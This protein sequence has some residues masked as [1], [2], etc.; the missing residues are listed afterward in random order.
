MAAAVAAASTKEVAMVVATEA[1]AT[2]AVAT[3]A[4]AVAETSEVP[5][6]HSCR[7]ILDSL[8]R[9]FPTTICWRCFHFGHIFLLPI[10]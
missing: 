8:T 10:P 2:E 4:A 1:V 9:F 3:E 5:G 7:S 6:R